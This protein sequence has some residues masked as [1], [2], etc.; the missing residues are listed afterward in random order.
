MVCNRAI[1]TV[2]G[3]YFWAEIGGESGRNVFWIFYDTK[4]YFSMRDLHLLLYF[5]LIQVMNNWI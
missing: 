4:L 5:I 3:R 2:S 1:K